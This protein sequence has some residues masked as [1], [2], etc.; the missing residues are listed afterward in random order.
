MSGPPVVLVHELYGTLDDPALV[1]EL[2]AA[3]T[4]SPDLLG[5]GTQAAHSVATL[6]AQADHVAAAMAHLPRPAVLVGHSLGGAVGVLVA[7][8][9]PHRVAGLVSIEGNMAP[10][11]AFFTAALAKSSNAAVAQALTAT[12]ANPEAWLRD[13]DPPT[14]AG[15]R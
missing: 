4:L 9:H 3:A 6:E 12:R 7:E 11:D 13:V 10:A 2:D 5:Y 15:T 8:R 1:A 14:H